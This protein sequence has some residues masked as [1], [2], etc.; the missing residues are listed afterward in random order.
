MLPQTG[1]N[2]HRFR[3]H[4]ATSGQSPGTSRRGTAFAPQPR[5]RAKLARASAPGQ[6]LA[7]RPGA[8]VP[9]RPPLPPRPHRLSPRPRRYLSAGRRTWRGPGRGGGRGGTVAGT[10]RLPSFSNRPGLPARSGRRTSPKRGPS[11]RCRPH[12][13]R[14]MPGR[15]P[16]PYYQQAA[17]G[18]PVLPRAGLHGRPPAPPRPPPRGRGPA[19]PARPRPAPVRPE[20]RGPGAPPPPPGRDL[21]PPTSDPG[22]RALCGQ[23]S[24]PAPRALSGRRARAPPLRAPGRPGRGRC[25]PTALPSSPGQ[26]PARPG[27]EAPGPL[28]GARA[29][30]ASG[31]TVLSALGVG[32]GRARLRDAGP[33]NAGI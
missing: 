6:G 15:L 10:A 1:I 33:A 19:R 20:P 25:A 31:G 11:S 4:F 5:G 32:G 24:R 29:W 28:D 7:A 30:P 26:P 8:P 17:A 9:P 13:L 21:R 22:P 3:K 12:R 2:L 23:L 14:A 27:W 16:P 18:V